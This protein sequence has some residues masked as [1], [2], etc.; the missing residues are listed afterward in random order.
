VDEE[1]GGEKMIQGTTPTFELTINGDS[2]DLTKANAVVV[3]I[4]QGCNE[5]SLTGE[6]LEITDR[7]AISCYLPQ[8]TSLT[9]VG[10]AT[11]RIQ[12]NWTYPDPNGGED[13]RAATTIQTIQ[14][15]DNL[16]KQVIS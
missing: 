3:T 16:L 14:I 13:R 2:V 9:L 5:I 4:T 1:L 8:A 10:D 11:A 12:V 15:G 7:N 6:D